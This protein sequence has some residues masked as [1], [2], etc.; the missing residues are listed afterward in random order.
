MSYTA[1]QELVRN[2]QLK[3]QQLA[4]PLSITGNATP[5]SVVPTSDE[6]GIVFLR[7]EGV[8]QITPALNGDTAPTLVA[9]NDANG[10]FSVMIVIGE[11]IQK[12]LSAELVSRS[13]HST[14]DSA[15]LANT[16]GITALGDKIVLDCDT[17][18]NLSSA[19]LDACLIVRYIAA[20]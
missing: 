15:K 6:R 8:N 1:K 14:A 2:R 7:T 11:Q 16:N 13:A 12:V 17:A 19:S 4:I 3:V 10:L 20:E 5:A 9:Q 18:V